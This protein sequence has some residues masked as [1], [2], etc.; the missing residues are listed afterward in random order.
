MSALDE[1]VQR[2]V[3]KA[4][5]KG[6]EKGMKEERKVLIKKL[7]NDGMSVKEIAEI[8]EIDIGEVKRF[9]N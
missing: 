6:M 1:Y 2:R 9:V 8:T 5:E 3:Q 4:R 7:Y